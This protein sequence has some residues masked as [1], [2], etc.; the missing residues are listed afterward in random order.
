MEADQPPS[1]VGRP[2]A[3]RCADGVCAGRSPW[4][5]LSST[6]RRLL[7]RPAVVRPGTIRGVQLWRSHGHARVLVSIIGP[8][9]RRSR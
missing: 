3:R 2:A 7:R 4:P 8:H 5:G 1:P 9:R 6:G